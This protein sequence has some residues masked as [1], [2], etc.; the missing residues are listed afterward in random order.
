M[1]LLSISI[2]PDLHTA[3][4]SDR[5]RSSQQSSVAGGGLHDLKTDQVHTQLAPI[6]AP[7][8]SSRPVIAKLD[9]RSKCV[10]RS[11][12]FGAFSMPKPPVH[13]RL[14]SVAV[15]TAGRE[16]GHALGV[17]SSCVDRASRLNRDMLDDVV[18]L[19]VRVTP[20]DLPACG[21]HRPH[22][23]LHAWGV[24]CSLVSHSKGIAA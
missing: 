20:V 6:V 17:Q 24:K 14:Q 4:G 7:T 19:T 15:A 8:L 22:H 3:S 9:S 21:N 2:P 10:S 11:I 1:H 18:R 16:K 23:V 5:V 12:D 13:V